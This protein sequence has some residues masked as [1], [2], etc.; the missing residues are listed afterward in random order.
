MK[1]IGIISIFVILFDRIIKL[2]V[3]KL[4]LL[5]VKNKV[6][7]NFFYLTKCYNNGAAFSMF[8]GN[9]LFLILITILALFIIYKYVKNNK[10]NK[11]NKISYGL[12]LGGIIG[13][14][15]DRLFYGYV[16]DY[17][18]FIIF[19]YEFAIFNLA[20]ICI[21]VGAILILFFDWGDKDVKK[22]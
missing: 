18:N 13:N 21:V 15:I 22:Y 11:I 5:N 7:N 6:I 1:Q 14:L 8:S 16:I 4:L 19:K 10:L 17:L 20:D 2:F 12:L 9:I 3:D